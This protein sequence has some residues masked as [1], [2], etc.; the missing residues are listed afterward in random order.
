MR[1]S[2]AMFK[3]L[4][5]GEER[6]GKGR[7]GEERGGEG[8]EG[9]CISYLGN[10]R[11]G[12]ER[13]GEERRGEERRGE[14]GREKAG[15]PGDLHNTIKR[16]KSCYMEHSRRG[17]NSKKQ[18]GCSPMPS[19]QLEPAQEPIGLDWSIISTDSSWNVSISCLSGV[20]HHPHS[21]PIISWFQISQDD[22][23]IQAEARAVLLALTIAAGRREPK[24]WLR[25]DALLFVDVILH[26]HNSP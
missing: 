26:P 15:K 8:V 9:E 21:P 25:C 5:E 18:E 4:G 22:K 1:A 7:E 12:E 3:L 24:I 2:T 10:F 13:R 11:E 17:R 14:C 23:P 19:L 20:L 6:G 16:I